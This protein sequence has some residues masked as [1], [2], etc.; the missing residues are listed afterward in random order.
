MLCSLLP[1]FFFL[2]LQLANAELQD[3]EATIC[4]LRGQIS[5]LEADNQCNVA[6]PS[7]VATITRQCVEQNKK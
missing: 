1:S 3:K 4:K 2:L 6:Q 5:V 7:D